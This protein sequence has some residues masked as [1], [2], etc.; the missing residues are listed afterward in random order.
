MEKILTLIDKYIEVSDVFWGEE[1]CPEDLKFDENT[2]EW[3]K[4]EWNLLE[5]MD[6]LKREILKL[7]KN[8]KELFTKYLCLGSCIKTEEYEQAEIFKNEILE[9]GK[10]S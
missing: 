7:L 8:D 10:I 9:Y 3:M 1:Q 6:S 4:K 2:I 5:E